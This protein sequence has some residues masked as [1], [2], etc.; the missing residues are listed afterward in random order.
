M[1]TATTNDRNTN[2]TTA[3]FPRTPENGQPR[4]AMDG[5]R[6]EV[7]LNGCRISMLFVAAAGGWVN[8]KVTNA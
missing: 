8:V 1:R 4:T 2:T 6:R 7:V 5:D 3:A